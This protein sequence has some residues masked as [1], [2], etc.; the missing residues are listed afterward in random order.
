MRFCNANI[1]ESV[2]SRNGA[3][4]LTPST[5]ESGKRISSLRGVFFFPLT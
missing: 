5:P 4:N 1:F 2:L 3:E